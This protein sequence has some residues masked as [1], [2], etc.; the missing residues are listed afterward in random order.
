[1]QT[2]SISGKSIGPIEAC[3]EIGK[4][5]AANG[6]KGLFRGQGIGMVKAIMSLSLFHEGRIW[7]EQK[8]TNRNY[9]N[10]WVETEHTPR[11][12]L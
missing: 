5:M 7:C 3:K 4:D 1:M 10:D 11:F 9:A 8:F 2:S 6:L 12:Y